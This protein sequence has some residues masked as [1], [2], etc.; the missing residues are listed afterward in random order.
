VFSAFLETCYYTRE[1]ARLFRDG[2]I[3][4]F[5]DCLQ[6][7]LSCEQR[8]NGHRT[9][10]SKYRRRVRKWTLSDHNAHFETRTS[11]NLHRRYNLRGYSNITRSISRL[12]SLASDTSDGVLGPFGIR[13]GESFTVHRTAYFI[14]LAWRTLRIRRLKTHTEKT[15]LSLSPLFIDI[16][17]PQSIIRP[18]H[19]STLIAI[20]SYSN[21]FVCV[22]LIVSVA[23]SQVIGGGEDCNSSLTSFSPS[24]E[25]R[26][27][28]YEIIANDSYRERSARPPRKPRT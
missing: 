25:L 3:L 18:P 5:V 20:S 1:L 23:L 24:C 9:R 4:K 6:P 16:Y 15:D 10:V 7:V 22:S 17:F 2:G 13:T 8:A 14:T 11:L 28:F 12:N 19:R 26:R 21:R 27:G